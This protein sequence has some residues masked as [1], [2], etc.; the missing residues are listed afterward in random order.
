M[1]ATAGLERDIAALMKSGCVKD[2]PHAAYTLTH[3]QLS[4]SAL[5]R[6]RPIWTSMRLVCRV[7]ILDVLQPHA[8]CRHLV[9]AAHHIFEEREL[10]RPDLNYTIPPL[11]GSFSEVGVERTDLE[12]RGP[13]LCWPTQQGVAR[14]RKTGRT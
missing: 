7:R 11:C 12:Y 1:A 13:A 9:F 2:E 14:Q 3:R 8:A 5:C 6:S 4:K 10:S